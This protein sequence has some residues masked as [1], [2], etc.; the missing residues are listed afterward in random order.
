VANKRVDNLVKKLRRKVR[1]QATVFIIVAIFIVLV[2]VAYFIFRGLPIGGKVPKDFENVYLYY[3]SCIEE[4][5]QNAALVLGERG[6]YIEDPEFFPGS[7]YMPF[8]SQLNF[9]G[10]GVPY[11][12]YV[13]GNGIQRE[14]VPSLAKLESQLDNYLR[15]RIDGCSFEIFER[16]G[17]EINF[18]ASEVETSIDDHL[19]KVDVEQEIIFSFSDKT[20]T[21]ESHSVSAK[22]N[23]GKNY[24]L[25]KK[26]Y[27]NNKETMFLEYYGLDVLRLYAPVDGTEL[28]CSSKVW[29]VDNIREDLTSALESNVPAVKLKGDYYYLKRDNEYFVQDIGEDVDVNVNFMFV[30][31]W[32]LRLE[33]W[34]SED[35]ILRADPVG[36]Q[37]GLGMLGFCYVPYHFVYDFAYPVLIQIYSDEEIFQFPVVVVIDKTMPRE[38]VDAEGL[39]DVV[40][41]LC[42]HKNTELSVYTYDNHLDPIPA[43]I[44]FKCFDTTCTIGETVLKEEDAILTAMFPQCV[45][46]YIVA[47][48]EGYE[49]K[50]YLVSSVEEDSALIVLNKKYD[51]ELQVNKN[52]QE[53][54]S[55]YA[56]VTFTKDGDVLTVSYPE[57]TSVELTVGQYEIKTYIYSNSSIYL[58]GSSTEKCVTVPKAGFLG[59]FGAEEEKCFTIDVPSQTVEFAVSGGGTSNYYIGESELESFEKIIINAEGFG[60][61]SKVEDLQLNYNNIDISNLNII[62]E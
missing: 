62:F 21:A 28:G 18:G 59:F 13:S 12:Y 26:I 20:W 33:V 30:R 40:P 50:K 47:S 5:T 49:T 48:A 36:L 35:G 54:K 31:E 8:S 56:V 7:T 34:P 53:V 61:P 42:E 15:D 10:I 58:E 2:I 32:P 9:L 39:P 29:S 11:W 41:E 37:E 19:I 17:Y 27:L 1:A 23:L 51:L 4:E 16:Q 60:I 55:D 52:G 57:Q 24:N 25:A 14:Q 6:G 22:S 43:S 3:L 44:G 38:A 46:G 45:N